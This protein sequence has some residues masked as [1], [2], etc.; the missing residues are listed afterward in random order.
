VND[1]DTR[2]RSLRDEPIPP[3]LAAAELHDR[4]KRLSRRRRTR[5]F[6]AG[7]GA[8]IALA[9]LAV[10]LTVYE[11]DDADVETVGPPP[12]GPV[13]TTVTTTLPTTASLPDT[14][15][16][17]PGVSTP[18]TR[19]AVAHMEPGVDL[20]DGEVVKVWAEG[21]VPGVVYQVQQ[22]YR[23][24]AFFN[25]D[26]YESA[27]MQANANGR[28][29]TKLLVWA[30]LYELGGSPGDGRPDV[31]RLGPGVRDCTRAACE[32]MVHDGRDDSEAATVPISFAD[33]VVARAPQLQIDPAG[34][35]NHLQE[36]TVS[37]T[38]FRPELNV[39]RYL[40]QC[41]VGLDTAKEERCGYSLYTESGLTPVF[42]AKDGTF[43]TPYVLYD[44]LAYGSCRGAPGCQLSWVLQNG[45]AAATAPLDFGE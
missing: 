2:F 20:R 27:A 36:V 19:G 1:L 29:T 35:Y 11:S 39:S 24:G 5:R 26:R 7:L 14:G 13:A 45:P 4:A 37:G 38:G 25:C 43:S 22:C 6:G 40:G 3:A 23:S 32:I 30:T 18:P 17:N 41:P 12:T 28:A 9:V 34:P 44:T 21:L 33:D 10:G 16:P 31:G 15:V 8:L 42:V